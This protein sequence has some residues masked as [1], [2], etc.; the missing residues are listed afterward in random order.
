MPI[1]GQT[2]GRDVSLQFHTPQ[3]ILAIPANFI[4]SFDAKPD[5]PITKYK[6]LTGIINPLVFHEGWNLEVE[7]A[8][9]SPLLDSYW[10][11][12]ESAY[13]AGVDLPGSTVNQTIQETDGSVTQ[14]AYLNVQFTI[15]DMGMWKG[16]EFISQKM[17][18][19][20]ARRER[21]N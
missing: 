13:Y 7:I 16:N 5:S 19:F 1:S 3:G 12:A 11:L 9:I 21:L 17:S 20:A 4:T 15:T 18:G 10:A 2:I 6:P 8:R 14:W